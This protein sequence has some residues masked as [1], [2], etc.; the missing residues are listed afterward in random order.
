M[1]PAALS[2]PGTADDAG[3]VQAVQGVVAFL[4][5]PHL[6][7][8]NRR[9]AL[10]HPVPMRQHA[11][12][13]FRGLILRLLKLD[14]PGDADSHSPQTEGR[15]GDPLPGQRADRQGEDADPELAYRIL[16]FLAALGP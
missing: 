8:V 11:D 10:Y 14:G 3:E 16:G 4:A 7:L 5:L 9:R 1:P 6:P 15:V 13:Q 2:P 12:Q